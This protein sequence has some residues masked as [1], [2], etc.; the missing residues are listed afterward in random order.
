MASGKGA[1]N[2]LRLPTFIMITMPLTQKFSLQNCATCWLGKELP[3][4]NGLPHIYFI[5]KTCRPFLLGLGASEKCIVSTSNV[6]TKGKLK[7]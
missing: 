6:K 3:V 7:N 4:Q 2:K 1:L 5:N